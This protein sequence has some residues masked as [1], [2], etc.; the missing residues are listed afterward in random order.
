[1]ATQDSRE[2]LERCTKPDEASSG[3]W[4]KTCDA[5]TGSWKVLYRASEPGRILYT[6]VGRLA[7]G[8]DMTPMLMVR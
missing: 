5:G 3:D 6:R 7:G 1:V 4:K 8:V 2:A